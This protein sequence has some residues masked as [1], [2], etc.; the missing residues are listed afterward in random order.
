MGEKMRIAGVVLM[1]A[2]AAVSA[3]A[4]LQLYDGFNYA[5]GS[6]LYTQTAPNAGTWGTAGPS[7]ASFTISSGSLPIYSPQMPTSGNKVQLGQGNSSQTS[8]R[9]SLGTT[10]NTDGQTVYWSMLIRVDDITNLTTNAAGV[11]LAGF[12]TNPGDQT[13]DPS[14]VASRLVL[15]RNTSTDTTYFIGTATNVNTA[16]AVF[17]AGGHALGDT[18][19]VVGRYTF[20]TGSANDL[21]DMWI[22]PAEATLGQAVAPPAQLS[23]TGRDLPIA[24]G[25]QSFL[26]RQHGQAP[27]EWYADELRVGTT[28]GS[29]TPE[30]ASA[31]VIGL[32]IL[33]YLS[34]RR[35][36]RMRG[37]VSREQ[38]N[39]IRGCRV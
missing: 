4:Q 2:F 7:V 14:S 36:R 6:N 27:A 19:L 22:N 17:D 37:G 29:V 25:I 5:V 16:T 34:R 8:D 12:N 9:V 28:W 21:S 3:S 31:S 38:I 10:Y 33:G 39:R 18:V 32:A 30:P 11:Y 13:S 1:C 20:V 24:N 23:H 35:P 26:L 15:R